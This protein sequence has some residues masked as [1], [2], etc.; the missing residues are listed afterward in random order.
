MMRLMDS[1]EFNHPLYWA[2]FVLAGDGGP[3]RQ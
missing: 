1:A 3:L 2:P